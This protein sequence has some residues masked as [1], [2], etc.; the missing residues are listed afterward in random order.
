MCGRLRVPSNIS[1]VHLPPYSPELNPVENVWDYLRDNKLN[2]SVF[3]EYNA[4]VDRCC[5]A[6]NWL[7][8]TP[9]RIRSIATRSWKK[10]SYSIGRLV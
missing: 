7:T 10:N 6:W 5:I 4:I 3:N 2:N 8:E 9:D 1:L